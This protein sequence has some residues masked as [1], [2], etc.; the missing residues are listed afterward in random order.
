ML[1]KS[2]YFFSSL[3]SR[4]RELKLSVYVS[5][6]GN[7]GSC[8]QVAELCCRVNTLCC[9]INTLILCISLSIIKKKFYVF[10][11]TG[12]SSRRSRD[13]AGANSLRPAASTE[14]L[15]VTSKSLGLPAGFRTVTPQPLAT[16]HNRHHFVQIK[17]QQQEQG[18]LSRW[19]AQL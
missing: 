14:M 6:Q 8:K 17:Q 2:L 18:T 4:Q 5:L 3:L 12:K 9:R 19:G 1:M 11:L 10:L 13:S 7:V 15:G 16:Q